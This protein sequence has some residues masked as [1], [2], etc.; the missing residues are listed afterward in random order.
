MAENQDVNS[1]QRLNNLLSA[2]LKILE[3]L[4]TAS[5]TYSDELSKGNDKNSESLKGAEDKLKSL[6]K[7]F[8][9][10]N[11]AV[12]EINEETSTLVAGFASA[13]QEINSLSSL[14]DEFKKSLTK[15]ALQGVTLSR[16][17]RSIGGA[18][19]E[20]YSQALA[21][22]SDLV[23]TVASLAN[24][25]KED[26]LEIASKND[27]FAT[28]YDELIGLSKG[29]TEAAKTGTKED[30][31]RAAVLQGIV[32]SISDAHKEASKFN[33]IDEEHAE[34]LKEINE[35]YES[36]SKTVKKVTY[37]I[38]TMLSSGRGFTGLLLVGAGAL[39]EKF[40]EVGREMGYGIT[41]Y[42][43]FTTSI[44]LANILSK[45]SGDA[46][47]EMGK[48]LGDVRELTLGMELDIATFAYRLN[49]SG[50]E[51]AYLS[52]AFG[53]LQGL[54]FE[55]GENTLAY[56]ENLALAN[57]LIPNDVM[58]DVAQSSEFIAKYTKDGG[59]NIF[60]AALAAGKLGVNLATVEKITDHLLDY[61]S[62]VEDE[63][64]ASVLLGKDLNLQKARELAYNGDINGAMKEALDAAGG[65]NEF[66]KMDYY[67]RNAVAKAL[68]VSVSELQK[69]AAH[70]Q[71]LN[72]EL[73]VGAQISANTSDWW[74]TITES[75][76]GKGLKA[77]GGWLMTGTQFASQIAIIK[78]NM[79]GL[80]K[81]FTALTDVIGVAFKKFLAFIGLQKSLDVAKNESTAA[82]LA[83]N[84][85]PFTPPT[86]LGKKA[87]FMKG[88]V[89]KAAEAAGA[90]ETT[91]ASVGT[92]MIKN[93]ENLAAA[94]TNIAK[95][96][97][98][99]LLQIAGALLVMAGAIWV[100]SKAFQNFG[101]VKDGWQ[102]FGLFIGAIVGMAVMLAVASKIM[103][104]AS[105]EI[106]VAALLM[107]GFGAA[108]LLIGEGFKL[109]A[110]GIAT[111]GS[112]LPAFTQNIMGLVG[113]VVPILA[114]ASAF[115]IL[116][117]AL[118]MLGTAGLT[119]MPVLATLAGIGIGI[120]ALSNFMKGGGT[121]STTNNTSTSDPLLQE[122][123][124]LR[125][126]MES[127]KLAVYMDAIKVGQLQTRALRNNKSGH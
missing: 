38:E 52:H 101:E 124:G 30:I 106:G 113:M 46:I 80:L 79:P 22:A 1:N 69:M 125:S 53:D 40:H 5:K 20:S 70:Q 112:A 76:A 55:V 60:D 10:L 36:I 99:S 83:S 92:S 108:I 32:D 62:S 117:G 71:A 54:S 16:E 51:A 109:F 26:A 6:R 105:A 3:E 44:M 95:T 94:E 4:K 121:N 12:K 25:N 72:G 85:M 41:Q 34:F 93:S 50:E 81:P 84:L 110:D 9:G 75:V 47:R 98:P 11:A 63:M 29:L 39:V 100:I 126:D 116:S 91:G 87:R 33:N 56:G 45:E 97:S 122:I 17:I 48:E 18:S 114:L 102:A 37:T 88:G 123:I 59:K 120:A 13:G 35:D 15:T 78:T 90:V 65:I 23:G 107:L 24:L 82:A 49:L 111:I 28:K 74:E 73:G 31:K 115:S 77:M 27:E 57:G 8:S 68:G 58:K 19:K 42:K 64:E 2:R 7:Q 66:N 119:A 21:D 61:Q 67:Q 104:G 89:S 127:G 118:V 43:G 14:Q 103:A 86:G 96:P